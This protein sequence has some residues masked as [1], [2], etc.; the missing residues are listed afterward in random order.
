MT[1][2][3]A[4]LY[5]EN[6]ERTDVDAIGIETKTNR[7]LF[8]SDAVGN[9]SHCM[10]AVGELTPERKEDISEWSLDDSQTCTTHLLRHRSVQS[11]DAMD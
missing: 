5:C 9:G 6:D 2:L 3:C 4:L 11:L 10:T 7:R 8:V 1:S